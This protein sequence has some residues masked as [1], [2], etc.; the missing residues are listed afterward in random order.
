MSDSQK[1]LIDTDWLVSHLDDPNIR[2]IE[3][4][5]IK[6][7]A[8]DEGHIPGAL[9]WNWKDW[10]W[11]AKIRKFP[12]AEDFA[13]RCGQSGITNDTTVIF[14]GEP[15]QFGTYGWWVFSLLKHPDCR[16]LDGGK[17]RWRN[18]GH[19]FTTEIPEIK[20]N[21]YTPPDGINES[22]R[23]NR[24]DIL[25]NLSR[26]QEGGEMVLLDHRSFEEYNGELVNVPG[27]PDVGAERYGRIPGA[28]HLHF[29]DFLRED[30]S[31]KSH[32]ELQKMLEARGVNNTSDIISYCRLSHRATLAYFVMTELLG[33]KNVRNYD[34]SWTEWGSM[35]GMPIEN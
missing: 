29:T 25:K 11:D 13:I 30:T 20:P 26:F 21:S 22:M 5:W 15:I 24:E 12:R 31:F 4:N 32:D 18:E 10:L 9:G 19:P 23:A 14:Y 28:R 3:V 8:Y 33:Y 35:V 7:K 16:I 2:L 1:K 34:G 27:M 17:T 6:T